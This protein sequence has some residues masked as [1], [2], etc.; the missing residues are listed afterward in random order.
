MKSRNFDLSVSRRSLLQA[1][2]GLV[3]TSL[4]PGGLIGSARAADHPAIGTYPA[5]SSGSSVFIGISVPRTAPMPCRARTNSR[6]TSSRS[7]TSTPATT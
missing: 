4:L 6:A 5:G 3:G 7:S 2:A 1:G